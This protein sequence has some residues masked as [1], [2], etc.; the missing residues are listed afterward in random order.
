MDDEVDRLVEGWRTALPGVDVSPLEVL[1]RVARLARHLERQRSTVFAR[2][3]LETWSFDVLSALRRSDHREGLSP[4]QLMGQTLVTSGTMTNRLDHLEDR[5]LVQRSPDP[6]D[7]RSL[8]VRLTAAG[9]ERVDGAL[10]DLVGIE[11]GLLGSLDPGRRA[12]L[13]ELLKTLLTPFEPPP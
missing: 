7:G 4:G 3:D 5:D 11:D 12:R 6:R 1:S 10:V 2:H 8:R 13:A 9:Q